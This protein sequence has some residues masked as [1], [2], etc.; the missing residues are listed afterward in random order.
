MQFVTDE[1]FMVGR[2]ENPFIIFEIVF[3]ALLDEDGDFLIMG[4]FNEVKLGVGNTGSSSDAVICVPSI[5][6]NIF[7]TTVTCP[8]LLVAYNFPVTNNLI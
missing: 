5:L 3:E 4:R 1:H 8:P 7:L 6:S 2:D